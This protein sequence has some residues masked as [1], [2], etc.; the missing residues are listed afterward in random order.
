MT[1]LRL[2]DP[3]DAALV[4]YGGMVV[5]ALEAARRLFEEDEL[6]L[7][8][9]VPS[10]LAPLDLDAVSLM[11]AGTHPIVVVEEGTMRN[12]FGA[13]LLAALGDRGDIRSRAVR[14]VATAD[15]VLPNSAA[16]EATIL[17]D[18]DDIVRAVR[19]IAG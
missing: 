17:P 1:R 6:L 5:Y 13:E 16:L 2:G 11:L 18:A 7:D 12:G 10:C 14:R 4:A 19:T 8:V 9:V 15:T 3:C